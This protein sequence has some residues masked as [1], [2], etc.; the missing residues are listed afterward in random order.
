M[1]HK[2]CF[3]W[4]IARNTQKRGKLEMNTVG[5]GIWQKTL[6]NE[7]NKECTVQDMEY[8]E[9]TEMW[10]NEKHTLQDV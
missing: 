4:N 8:G 7:Q 2:H 6:K 9:K 1:R 10:K 3:T 5:P